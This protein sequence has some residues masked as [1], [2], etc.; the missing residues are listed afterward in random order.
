M[1][2]YLTKAIRAQE[3]DGLPERYTRAATAT[4]V[5]VRPRKLRLQ[6]HSP[7]VRSLCTE[8]RINAYDRCYGRFSCNVADGA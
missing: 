5:P 2:G 8:Q 6:D 7:F 1:D 4:A 3:L